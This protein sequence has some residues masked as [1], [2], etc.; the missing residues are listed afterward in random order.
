MVRMIKL[1][2]VAECGRVGN[3]EVTTFHNGVQN[4]I[5]DTRAAA[6]SSG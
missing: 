5:Q 4:P 1:A 3:V 6:F 2:K